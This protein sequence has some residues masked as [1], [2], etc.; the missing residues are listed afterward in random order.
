MCEAWE[1]EKL[2]QEIKPENLG[3]LLDLGHLK[4]TSNLLKFNPYE[5]I[6]KLRD[7]IR[8][9]HIHENYGKL[10]EHRC[11]KKKGDW[12]LGIVNRY[13]K[14]TNI[15]IVLE[16]KSKDERELKKTLMLLDGSNKHV[17]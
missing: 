7:K 11:I 4:V 2:F 13:F 10:D 5:F 3:I 16:C 17:I 15:P 12:S 6:Y 8:I 1:F 14:N 9:I